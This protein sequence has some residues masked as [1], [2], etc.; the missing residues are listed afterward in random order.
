MNRLADI[1]PQEIVTGNS[2][3]PASGRRAGAAILAVSVP[4]DIA[5][6]IQPFKECRLPP[7]S[8]GASSNSGRVNGVRLPD[9]PS[10]KHVPSTARRPGGLTYWTGVVDQVF[11]YPRMHHRAVSSGQITAVATAPS[12]A[13]D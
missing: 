3:R 8:G 2:T 4:V 10:L 13:G 12:D 1:D 9:G 5:D 6:E 11:A 7:L